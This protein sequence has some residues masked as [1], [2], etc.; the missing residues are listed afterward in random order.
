VVAV[1][2]TAAPSFS[3]VKLLVRGLQTGSFRQTYGALKTVRSSLSVRSRRSSS[4]RVS[5][6]ARTAT[7]V[8]AVIGVGYVG[9]GLVKAFSSH[10]NVIAIDVSAERIM[11]LKSEWGHLSSVEWTTEA[12]RMGSATHI[13]VTVPTLLKKDK[14]VDTKYVQAALSSI[15]E[16][17][18]PGTTIV[19][20]SSVAVG[21]TREMLGPLMEGKGFKGGMSPEVSRIPAS[22]TKPR[23]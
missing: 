11:S 10:Y 19:I 12:A 2:P 21:M 14:S 3:V 22:R 5:S 8:V 16:H 17:A 6:Q 15:Q 23:C 20:E 9:L 7:A 1:P 13:L 4:S 18:Q